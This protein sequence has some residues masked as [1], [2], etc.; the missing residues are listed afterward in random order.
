MALI[1]EGLYHSDDLAQI[2]FAEY[3]QALA[4][5]MPYSHGTAMQG[6]ELRVEIDPVSLGLDT[7]IPCGLIINELLSNALNHAFSSGQEGKVRIRLSS[8]DDELSLTVGD[9]GR[10]FPEDVDFHKPQSMGLRLVHTLVKQLDGTIELNR[11]A[12]TEFKINF[13]RK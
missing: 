9:N 3:V 5:E 11:G 6:V 4:K 10:G 1:H 7:A 12:G 2:D 8:H 13:P